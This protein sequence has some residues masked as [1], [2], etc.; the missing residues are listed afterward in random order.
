MADVSLQNNF[1]ACCLYVY[2]LLYHSTIP[3]ASI[4]DVGGASRMKFEEHYSYSSCSEPN[5]TA[6][7]E[8]LRESNRAPVFSF[9]YRDSAFTFHQTLSN[10]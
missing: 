10:N 4:N 9:Q 5:I 8:Y 3:M 2:G 7:M 1:I 6:S